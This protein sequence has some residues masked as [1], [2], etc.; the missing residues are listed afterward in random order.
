MLAL[1]T[2]GACPAAGSGGGGLHA[3][4]Q[5]GDR[6]KKFFPLTEMHCFRAAAMMVHALICSCCSA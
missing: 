6:R 2:P 3:R 1:A 5:V 4:A